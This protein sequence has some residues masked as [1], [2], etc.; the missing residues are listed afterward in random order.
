MVSSFHAQ[1]DDTSR[2]YLAG[3][4]GLNLSSDQDFSDKTNSISGE[5]EI[6]STPS[7]AGALGLRL[8]KNFRAEAE[9]SYR[10]A[11]IDSL[12][13]NFGSVNTGGDLKSWMGLL[14]LYYDFDVDWK[15]KP[16]VSAGL[17]LGYFDGE[18]TSVNGTRFSDSA[19]GLTWQAG[20]G[21]EYRKNKD[22]SWTAGYRYLDSA[23][24]DFG[25]LDLDYGAHEIRVGVKYDLDWR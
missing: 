22:W 4:M 10:N 11:D 16:Y 5:T 21:L 12:S 13:G 20:A 17:G 15:V 9:L 23:D 24:L 8:N 19:Y 2:F 18:V 6:A 25:D 14:N 3:Y 7:F 1:A